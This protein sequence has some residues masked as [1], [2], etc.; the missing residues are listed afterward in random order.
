MALLKVVF[1][2]GKCLFT[3]QYSST[4]EA[5]GFS[6]IETDPDLNTRDSDSVSALAT[7]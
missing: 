4:E 2:K 3:A 6:R 5:K 1:Q 7:T